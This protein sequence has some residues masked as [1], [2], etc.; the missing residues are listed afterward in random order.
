MKIGIDI[1]DTITN[2]YE[3]LFNY[4]QKYTTEELNK[5][6]KIRN[7]DC[8][9]H[10]Y[11]EKSHDWTK[12]EANVFWSK[13]YHPMIKNVRP[14]IFAIEYI[15]ELAKGNEIYLI[16]AR[17][18]DETRTA[19]KLTIEWLEKYDVPYKEL[20]VQAEDKLA[21]AKKVGIDVFIDDSF[22]NCKQ[23]SEGGIKSYMIE[24]MI[25]KNLD[26]SNEKFERV[27]SWPHLYQ[28]IK[29]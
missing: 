8:L 5:T 15:K 23:V 6:G 1:D 28:E 22:A 12:E 13:Y 11:T 2:T 18:D 20:F 25:N 29:K 26:I 24:S 17:Y 3:V 19:E 27:Y 4:A 21:V 7:V 14:K 9:T 16:T 10:G